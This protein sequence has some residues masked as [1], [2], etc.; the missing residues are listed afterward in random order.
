M[1]IEQRLAT[2]L[3]KTAT[4]EPSPDLWSR[5]VHSIEEDRN[6]RRRVLETVVA[7][8]G[9]TLLLLAVGAAFMVEGAVGH[10]VRR[11][12]ME[13]LEAVALGAMTV[14]LGPAIRRFG[15]GYAQDLWPVGNPTPAALLRLLDL[16][17]YLILAG[18][19][20]MSTEFD[21]ADAD[22]LGLLAG[23]LGDAAI[24]VGGLM[25]ILGLLHAVTLIALPVVALIDNST[26]AS[27]RSSR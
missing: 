26:R 14:A 6:H 9:I 15:R 7:I 16:A 11:P 23:Q 4:V 21:F 13:V 3:R 25:L 8:G 19:I 12:I 27:H 2:A 5:V 18:Y 1:N 24:R 17:Y 10:H 20:L 22:E